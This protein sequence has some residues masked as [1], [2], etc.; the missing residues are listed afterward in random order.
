MFNPFTHLIPTIMEKEQKKEKKINVPT[1]RDYIRKHLER[2][3]NITPMTAFFE[4]GAYRLGAIIHV[5][6]HKEHM[7]IVTH[8]VEAISKMTGR[9]VQFAHYFYKPEQD[10]ALAA[11]STEEA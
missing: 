4:Y 7:P 11:A 2:Y 5:L 1:Q 8:R 6:R 10:T 9:P 3:G